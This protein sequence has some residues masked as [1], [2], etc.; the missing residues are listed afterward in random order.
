MVPCSRAQEVNWHLSIYQFTLHTLVHAGFE[1]ATLHIP[2]GCRCCCPSIVC[3][4]TNT[5]D[6]CPDLV[7][8]IMSLLLPNLFIFSSCHRG[9][10]TGVAA[11]RAMRPAKQ[12]AMLSLTEKSFDEDNIPS[13]P[14]HQ[15][16]QQSKTT[17]SVVVITIII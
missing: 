8:I 6:N 17:R 2:T 15:S 12:R 10:K 13:P 5:Q 4:A 3:S 7:F 16:V 1:L 9:R 14:C 11:R